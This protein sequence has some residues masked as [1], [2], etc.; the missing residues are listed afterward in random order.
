MYTTDHI[1][2]ISLR[3]SH[4][5]YVSTISNQR[6]CRWSS[7]HSTTFQEIAGRLLVDGLMRQLL[8]PSSQRAGHD[9]AERQTT[10]MR[11][12]T[13]TRQQLQ[14]PSTMGLNQR[15]Q[16]RQLTVCNIILSRRRCACS[17]YVVGSAFPLATHTESWAACIFHW[18]PR[19]VLAGPGKQQLLLAAWSI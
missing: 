11:Y 17:R 15:H 10:A 7:K 16:T 18:I 8:N 3:L 13:I 5:A 9:A 2:N 1:Y 4:G 14:D 6:P 12:Q 19:G